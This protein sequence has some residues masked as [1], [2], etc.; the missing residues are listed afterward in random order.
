[1]CAEPVRKASHLGVADGDA[2][3]ARQTKLEFFLP[4][5]PFGGTHRAS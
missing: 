5:Y 3:I 2:E 4:Y 1:M